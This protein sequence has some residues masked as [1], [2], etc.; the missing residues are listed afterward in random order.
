MQLSAVFFALLA[1]LISACSGHVDELSGEELVAKYCTSCHLAPIPEQLPKESWPFV[2]KWMGNYLGFRD[3]GGAL[4]GIVNIDIIPDK[5]L[6]SAGDFSKIESY[7]VSKSEPQSEMFRSNREYE[8]TDAFHAEYP[9]KDIAKG[10][11]ITLVRHDPH[12]GYSFVGYGTENNKRLEVYNRQFRKIADYKM[13]SEPIHLVP[14]NPG[15]RLSLIG[16][17]SYDKGEGEVFEVRPGRFGRLDVRHL[18]TGYNRMTQSLAADF[19][20]DGRTDLLVVG[21]GQGHIGRT[22]VVHQ[23]PNGRYGD[24]IIFSNGSGSLCAE[25]RDFDGNGYPDIMLLVAQ[26][27]QELLLFLNQGNDRYEKKLLHKEFAGFGYNHFTLADVN[28]DDKIDI[29]TSNG[30]NMEITEVPLKPH[31]GIRILLNQGN[32]TWKE[33]YFFPLHGAIKSIAEDFDRDGDIDIAAIA[34]YPN[35]DAE[36]PTTFVYLRNTG[37]LTFKASTLSKEHWGRWMVMDSG[38]VDGDGYQDLVLGAAY[39]NKGIAPRYEDRYRV[40]AKESQPLLFLYNN[41]GRHQKQ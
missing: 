11:F 24:E 6:I 36:H 31:H 41:G 40:L 34:F 22:S 5:P 16:D 13:K 23:L 21:F 18:I 4:H 38:D 25:V 39:I 26:E 32:L 3:T 20:Q 8:L 17:F 33:V 15:F 1:A 19:N 2:L 28:G 12:S 27:H 35:W 37:D 30:N 29:V 9:I 14:L 10:E 7:L